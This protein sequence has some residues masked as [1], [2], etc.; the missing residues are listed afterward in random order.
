M[1]SVRASL[2]LPDR[3]AFTG[4]LESAVASGARATVLLV[5]VDGFR[6]VNAALGH[7]GR[8]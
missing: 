2:P 5:D 8:V 6:D 3:A 1:R 7:A 4:R